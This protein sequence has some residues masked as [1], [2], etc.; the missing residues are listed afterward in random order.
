MKSS[1][2]IQ[3]KLFKAW[4]KALEKDS[5]SGVFMQS[6]MLHRK[7][8]YL[9]SKVCGNTFDFA[10]AGNLSAGLQDFSFDKNITEDLDS[11][12][13]KCGYAGE[14]DD[15][16]LRF[17]F[18]TLFVP[19]GFIVPDEY[20]E[21]VC[22]IRPQSYE[23]FKVRDFSAALIFV[24]YDDTVQRSD[25][26]GYVRKTVK[27]LKEKKVSYIAAVLKYDCGTENIVR[28][29]T[30]LSRCCSDVIGIGPS[31][32]TA[33]ADSENIVS[34]LGSLLPSDS[35]GAVIYRRTVRL[36][37]KTY[38]NMRR[39]YIPVAVLP[40]ENSLSMIVP[41][42]ESTKDIRREIARRVEVLPEK[43]RQINVGQ[44]LEII[45]VS[46]PSEYSGY[47]EMPLDD[48]VVFISQIK[49]C[50]TVIFF[51]NYEPLIYDMTEEEYYRDYLER[52]RRKI[53]KYD[54]IFVVSSVKLPPDIPHVVVDDVS[55]SHGAFCRYLLSLYDLD[56]KVAI[57]GSIGKTTCKEMSYLVLS[58]KYEPLKSPDNENLQ[59][60]MSSVFTLLNP[61]YNA[62]IQ[63]MGG[64]IP[65]RAESFSK[66]VEP[67]AAIVTTIGT[68][69]LSRSK[70]REALAVNKT[71][72]A[73]GIRNGGP[74]LVNFD[75][76]KLQEI[77]YTGRNII[78][79]AIDNHSADYYAQS[80]AEENDGITFEIVHGDRIYPAK[81]GIPG[82]HNV[83]NAL[84]S[85]II[86][87]QAG[88]P[89]DDI[90][91]AIAE[92]RPEGIRQNIEMIG[93]YR[94]YIDCYNASAESMTS[95][96]KTLAGLGD[97]SRKIAFLADMAELGDKS[98]EYH[99]SVGKDIS[100]CDIDFLIGLGTEIKNTCDNFVNAKAQV[101][102]YENA[103][104][105]V[106]KL[107]ELLVPGAAVLFK[108]SRNTNLDRDVIDR[109]FGTSYSR[110]EYR[111]SKVRKSV[112]KNIEYN[113]YP[114]SAD[115]CGIRDDSAASIEIA[116]SVNG[117][118]VRSVEDGAFENCDNAENVKFSSKLTNIGV[119]AFRNCKAMRNA[120]LPDSLKI[121]FDGAFENCA[122]LERVRI[123]KG[124][125]HIGAR[126]FADCVSLKTVELPDG[127]GYIADSAF[128]GCGEIRFVNTDPIHAVH[129][130]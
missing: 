105:A 37:G 75:N 114:Q 8:A 39:Y 87:E 94:L 41:R 11:A 121:I 86:G 106:A 83:Y 104:D 130:F 91:C 117:R 1:V 30:H 69:H 20:R 122:S 71:N 51:R 98:A 124:I 10:V 128:D 116:D 47:A 115:V 101:F 119:G 55:E 18:N 5:F 56:F 35:R 127:V 44:M 19:E 49:K 80:I 67:D 72:I 97:C 62:Y 82:R 109:V 36:T 9:S 27:I 99:A 25:L 12:R 78:T 15:S 100:G 103:D 54:R 34:D 92:F 126:A 81:L 96:V 24:K 60:K 16:F 90:I 46:M 76:D 3:K 2:S 13:L 108:G 74:L 58:K 95:A 63:E 17:G 14:W 45:G 118:I 73:N 112:L 65:G 85:F 125:T 66:V 40:K 102:C 113:F 28:T 61:R 31:G 93:G 79:F 123:G 89:Y 57:T 26:V 53:I 6:L 111:H 77:D 32:D 64:G 68:A 52:L 29:L 110:L 42:D 4:R 129:S 43:C 50:N 48:F 84:T 38:Y 107:E 33:K 22:I 120:E 21:K 59:F 70:T 23:I 88:V 7:R